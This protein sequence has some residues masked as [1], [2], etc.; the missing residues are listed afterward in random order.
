VTSAP[1]PE[2]ERLVSWLGTQPDFLLEDGLT[3]RELTRAEQHF[4]LLFP[5]IWREVLTAVHPVARPKPPRDEDG[6]RRWTACP[7][8]RLRDETGTRDLIDAP[9]GGLLF[10]VEQNGFWWA[11]WG[12]RPADT[13]AARA[14]AAVRL[15]TVP[16]LVPLWG[17]QYVAADDAS[18]VFSIVQ[19]DLYIPALTIADVTTG[20][21][22]DAVSVDEWPIG[23]VPFWS[24]LH[25]YS[26]LG[27]HSR[28]AHLAT[29]GL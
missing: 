28:F 7:D 16:R 29:G 1:E 2:P 26:Q 24:D 21:N 19:A 15:A 18:P 12:I 23:R 14:L 27:P 10:D 22:Q 25:A 5:P 11:D 4:A 8:W 20:R 9:V 13:P 17:H 6:V 3:E